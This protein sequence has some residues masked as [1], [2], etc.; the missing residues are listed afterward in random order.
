M[1]TRTGQV[2]VIQARTL[3]WQ[4]NMMHVLFGKSARSTHSGGLL[5]PL[6]MQLC[7]D[8]K[9]RM[10]SNWKLTAQ[11]SGHFP[12]LSLRPE[13]DSEQTHL[14]LLFKT[15]LNIQ[16][17]LGKRKV[18]L[19][20]QWSACENAACY[21]RNTTHCTLERLENPTNLPT[22]FQALHKVG[23]GWWKFKPL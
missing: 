12:G 6:L 9:L 15:W 13:W 10:F 22:H 14:G 18:P 23:F 21:F 3:Q 4:W 17:P 8:A 2:W 11:S 19:F 7:L 16:L 20:Q 1:L 5:S